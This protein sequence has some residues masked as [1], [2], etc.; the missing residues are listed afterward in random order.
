[1]KK[2]IFS[3]ML[4]CTFLLASQ[5][6]TALA[7]QALP[8]N[9]IAQTTGDITGNGKPTVIYLTGDKRQDSPLID[10]ITL[11]VTG[12]APISPPVNAGYNA[13]LF[14]GDFTGDKI[15]DVLVSVYTDGSGALTSGSVY[16]FTGK[17]PTLVFDTEQINDAYKYKVKYL[18]GYKV[19]VKSQKNRQK[20]LI[21][22][23]NR[24]R[25][26]LDEIYDKDGKLKAPQEGWV[27]PISALFPVD[28]EM[29]GDYELLTWQRVS[30]LYHADAL[31]YVQNIIKY[32]NGKWVLFEQ[33]VGINGVA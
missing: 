22:I 23:S 33:Y 15:N 2:T 12:F 8:A 32:Q 3:C 26:Y 4:L 11:H 21:D 29:N 18:D 14:V 24:D 17:A 13:S 27:D 10:N 6:H 31:G 16:T 19:E 20:Y 9:V 30:G 1:M 7:N 5:S 28:V 25:A